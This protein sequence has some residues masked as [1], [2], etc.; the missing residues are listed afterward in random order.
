MEYRQEQR[1]VEPK[2]RE[3]GPNHQI[4]SKHQDPG[5]GKR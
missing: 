1:W 3:Q 4:R 2:E 5:C